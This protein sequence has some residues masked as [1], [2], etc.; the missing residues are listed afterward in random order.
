MQLVA[1]TMAVV[2]PKHVCN[3]KS[4]VFY[5]M[6]GKFLVAPRCFINSNCCTDYYYKLL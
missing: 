3:K 2:L 4:R 1:L 5:E 6:L